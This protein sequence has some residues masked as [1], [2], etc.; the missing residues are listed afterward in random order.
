MVIYGFHLLDFTPN[1]MACMAIFAHLCENFVGVTPNVDLFRNYFF[2]RVQNMSRHLGDISWMPRV[3]PREN[4]DYI[5]GQQRSRWEEWRGDWCWI[6][7]KD[8]PEFCV[9][10]TEC[11]TRDIEWSKLGLTDDRLRPMLNRIT[12]LK[13]SGLTVEHVGADFLWRRIAPLQKRDRTAWLYGD[14][15]DRMRLYPG[16]T[17]NL[18]VYGHGWLCEHQLGSLR[19]FKLLRRVSG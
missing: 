2:P 4:W 14:A 10:R 19:K 16:L 9:A 3:V 1:A 17:N 6:Q 15:G 8:A 13:A 12:H 5:F 7:D 18:S 11:I